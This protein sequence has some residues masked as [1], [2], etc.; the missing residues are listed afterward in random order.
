MISLSRKTKEKAVEDL[1][2]QNYD[3]YY[4]LAYSYVHNEADAGEIAIEAVSNGEGEIDY[5]PL[6]ICEITPQ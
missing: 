1:L 6:G 4:R 2:L 3:Q 5:E